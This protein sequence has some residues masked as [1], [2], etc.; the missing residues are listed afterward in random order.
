[1]TAFYYIN[2]ITGARVDVPA[3]LPVLMTNQAPVCVGVGGAPCPANTYASRLFAVQL[4]A[5]VSPQQMFV[6]VT[7][8]EGGTAT[9]G[10][11]RVR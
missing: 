2:N 10:I 9:K 3:G 5:N 4:P 7:S 11:T 1:V 8:S 6:T